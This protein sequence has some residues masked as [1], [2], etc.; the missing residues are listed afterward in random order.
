MGPLEVGVFVV[1]MLMTLVLGAELGTN[2]LGATGAGY[3]EMGVLEGVEGR[4]PVEYWFTK[5]LRVVEGLA[6]FT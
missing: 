6:T 4:E 3:D 1:E 5:L 2:P